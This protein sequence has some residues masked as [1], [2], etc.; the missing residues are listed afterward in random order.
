MIFGEFLDRLTGIPLRR[1]II[2]AA[3]I[4][5]ACQLSYCSG[6][7]RGVSVER[8]SWQAKSAAII[9]RRVAAGLAAE[10]RDSAIKAQGQAIIDRRKELDDATAGIP[11]Q[12]LS[13]RQRARVQRERL[14]E[15]AGR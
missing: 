3:V 6:Y 1:Y 4:V 7:R 10:K 5:L 11:D 15:Q 2:A 8:A 12:G 14:R 9:E 13:D